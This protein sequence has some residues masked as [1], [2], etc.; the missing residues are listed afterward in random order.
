MNSI[1]SIS[2]DKMRRYLDSVLCGD[3]NSDTSMAQESAPLVLLGSGS[4]YAQPFVSF[5]L[6]NLKV[7][8]VIDNMRI[9][10]TLGNFDVCGD[11]DIVKVLKV[12]PNAIGVIC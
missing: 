11:E 12:Y 3:I 9:G 2:L 10:Q 5:A 4:V 6:S 1:D 7:V 8:A